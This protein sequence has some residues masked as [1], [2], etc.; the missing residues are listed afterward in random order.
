MK[1]G[2]PRRVGTK[3]VSIRVLL[4]KSDHEAL[5]RIAEQERTDVGTLVRRAV[6][7]YFF[8]PKSSKTG[9]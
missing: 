4:M 3:S 1:Q 7:H 6:A 2:R 9:K 5:K 8:L